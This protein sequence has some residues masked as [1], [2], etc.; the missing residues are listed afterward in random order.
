VNAPFDFEQVDA[1]AECV[2]VEPL[3]LVEL[4]AIECRSQ[5]RGGRKPRRDDVY[6]AF[7]AVVPANRLQG[8]DFEAFKLAYIAEFRTFEL[9][10]PSDPE[11]FFSKQVT[12][13]CT[14]CAAKHAA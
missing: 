3:S 5:R 11:A 14:E 10:E 6:R 1:F 2:G 8:H 4:A 12:C 13:G 7:C 9:S